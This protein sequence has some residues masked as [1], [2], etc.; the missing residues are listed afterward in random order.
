MRIA[1]RMGALSDVLTITILDTPNDAACRRPKMYV[2]IIDSIPYRGTMYM[3]R[4]SQLLLPTP[5]SYSSAFLAIPL[6]L[7]LLGRRIASH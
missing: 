2:H 5:Y 6:I 3:L 7:M 1:T 4:S